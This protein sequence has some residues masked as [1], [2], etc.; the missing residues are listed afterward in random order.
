MRMGV[1]LSLL[2][3]SLMAWDTSYE[4]KLEVESQLHGRKV[5]HLIIR[6]IN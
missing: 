2:A 5:H 1:D 3:F 6:L 4:L